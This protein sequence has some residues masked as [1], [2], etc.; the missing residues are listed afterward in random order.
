MML[1]GALPAQELIL[2]EGALLLGVEAPFRVGSSG[3][4]K[5]DLGCSGWTASCERPGC[6]AGGALIPAC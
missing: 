6:H 1:L 2:A 3:P 5:P 4:A